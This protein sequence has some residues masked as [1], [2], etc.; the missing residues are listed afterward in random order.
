MTLSRWSRRGLLGFGLAAGT[1]FFLPCADAATPRLTP[2]CV[3]A[4]DPTPAQT[5]GPY[6]TPD[7]P[8]RS[9]L[10][11]DG[12]DGRRISLIGFALDRQCRPIAGALVDLW[13]ADA[14][15]RYDNTGYNLRGHVFTDSQGRFRFDTVVPGL[16][17]GRTRH[18]HVKVQPPRGRILTT[19][20]YFPGEPANDRD[21]IYDAALLL[22][23]GQADGGQIGR[24]EFVL[25]QI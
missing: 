18:F 21:R 25:G 2:A 1:G 5:E 22:D 16:Y 20:L 13:H 12:I 15:G 3:E 24:F 4:D 14:T 7:S 23:V 10:V 11:T 17:P 19:Q 8:E 9:N 6:F